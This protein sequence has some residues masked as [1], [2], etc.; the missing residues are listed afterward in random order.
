MYACAVLYILVSKEVSVGDSSKLFGR[1][2]LKMK[3]PLVYQ[4][5]GVGSLSLLAGIGLRQSIRCV[6]PC[7]MANSEVLR[8][9]TLYF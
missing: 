7:L 9:K 1:V 2:L 4:S 3:R 6:I 8:N 5:T